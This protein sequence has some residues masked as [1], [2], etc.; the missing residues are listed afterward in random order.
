MPIIP[1]VLT[2]PLEY[3]GKIRGKHSIRKSISITMPIIPIVL[4][5]NCTRN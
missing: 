5:F 2:L 3:V 4:T 1:I